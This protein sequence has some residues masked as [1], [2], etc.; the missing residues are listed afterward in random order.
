MDQLKNPVS[1]LYN[2]N[3]I[4]IEKKFGESRMMR[5]V[6]LYTK[7]KTKKV[8][9]KQLTGIKNRPKS[10]FWGKISTFTKC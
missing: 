1:G 9:L 7:I 3:V 5:F 6:L 2:K 8:S 10:T 4:K